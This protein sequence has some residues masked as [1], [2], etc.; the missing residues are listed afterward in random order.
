VNI[1]LDTYSW[2]DA[3]DGTHV[4]GPLPE[5][6]GFRLTDEHPASSYGQP[7]LVNDAGEAFGAADIA[8]ILDSNMFGDRELIGAT[9]I[10]NRWLAAHPET[11]QSP[12]LDAA[13][14]FV[15]LAEAA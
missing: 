1:A 8:M 14:R 12:E 2:T 6:V 13:R 4:T 10:V 3:H 9:R 5:N 11:T 7:V 15:S